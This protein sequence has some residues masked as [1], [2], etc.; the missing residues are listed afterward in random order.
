MIL[1]IETSCDESAIAVFD[2]KQGLLKELIHTQIDLHKQYG[3]VV[4]ELAVREHLTN[5]PLLL[6]EIKK[7]VELKKITKIAVT[8]GP[9]L[10]GSLAIGISMAKAIS[11]FHNIPVLGINHLRSHAY[12]PFINLHEQ[13]PDGFI[14]A[15]DKYLP[16]LGLIAS[17]GNTLLFLIEKD[18]SIKIIGQ[19]LD[20][21]A[22]EALDKGA[23]MLGLE[24]PGGPLIE[25]MAQLGSR[26]KF[27]FPRALKVKKSDFSFSGLKTSLRYLLEKMSNE[28]I[29]QEINNLCASYQYAVIEQLSR[30][31]NKEIK[32]KRYKSL[33]L[34]GG[35]A[36]NQL[37]QKSF[38]DIS[39]NNNVHFLNAQPQHTGDN[40][41]MIAFA[42]YI[43]PDGVN[44]NNLSFQSSLP[45]S[46]TSI[47]LAHG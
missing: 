10:A 25:K 16:H 2:H 33:G 47:Q 12:S 27:T 15:L 41:G 19:T 44:A 38:S 17:G 43:D 35:V 40:A 6:S 23:K 46:N 31:A 36:N 29:S 37:L 11:L 30:K 20:D 22:G 3:G 42:A 24:Y 32:T 13:N 39:K 28:N 5:L 4:P 1:G 18:R 9:G 26:D 21:A 8:Q 14:P 45:L 7:N 34:S